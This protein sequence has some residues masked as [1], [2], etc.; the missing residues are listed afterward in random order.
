MG[1]LLKVWPDQQQYMSSAFVNPLIQGGGRLP[2][3]C[4]DLAC[5]AH[6]YSAVPAQTCSNI[7]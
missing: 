1:V 3:E 6:T 7:S 4:R 2:A 5:Q